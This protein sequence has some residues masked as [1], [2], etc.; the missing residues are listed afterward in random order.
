MAAENT[1]R[2]WHELYRLAM[3]ERDPSKLTLRISEARKAIFDR[4]EQAFADPCKSKEREQLTD[5]LNGL[6]TIQE[7]YESRIQRFGEPRKRGGP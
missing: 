5:A 7:Q 3:A 2:E 4:I 6:R 1:S